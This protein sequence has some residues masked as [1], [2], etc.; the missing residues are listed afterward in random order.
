M[1]LNV[2]TYKKENKRW[3]RRSLTEESK[4]MEEMGL[5]PWSQP[6]PVPCMYS[7]ITLHTSPPMSVHR[8]PVWRGRRAWP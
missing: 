6:V 7:L 8:G 4:V 5:A 1:F 2:H 3:G